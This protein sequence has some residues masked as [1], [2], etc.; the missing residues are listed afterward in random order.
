MKPD[1]YYITIYITLPYFSNSIIYTCYIIIGWI[2][3]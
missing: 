3:N 2:D 1:N